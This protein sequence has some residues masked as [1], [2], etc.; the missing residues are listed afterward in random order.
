MG[1]FDPS[2]QDMIRDISNRISEFNTSSPFVYCFEVV[3][4]ALLWDQIQEY[5]PPPNPAKITDPR[6]KDYIAKY[7]PTSWEVDALN[8]ELLNLLLTKEI[9][10]NLDEDKYNAVLQ[11]ET[12]HRNQLRTLIF[13]L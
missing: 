1:I 4:I 11:L 3:P 9:T 2:G 12:D 7:G 13:K 10:R 6:A 5:S 8:P